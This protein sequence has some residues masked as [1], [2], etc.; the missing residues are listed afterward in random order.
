[1]GTW[2]AGAQPS[3]HPEGEVRDSFLHKAGELGDSNGEGR[4]GE[5]PQLESS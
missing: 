4:G 3:L 2:R 5:G 1:M